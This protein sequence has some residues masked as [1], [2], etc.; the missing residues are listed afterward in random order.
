MSLRYLF[1]TV[2]NKRVLG[3]YDFRDG[4]VRVSVEG[5]PTERVVQAPSAA[6]AREL[7]RYLVVEIV[8]AGKVHILPPDAR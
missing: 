1:R 8:R 7:A 6:E 2:D 3:C 4:Q 5:Y